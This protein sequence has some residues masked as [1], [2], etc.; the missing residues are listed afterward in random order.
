M[1]FY[2]KWWFW[3]VVILAILIIFFFPKSCG[4]SGG[5]GGPITSIDC[6]CIGVKGPPIF[7]LLGGR[8][9][10]A[11]LTSCYGICLKN[12]CETTIIY[13]NGTRVKK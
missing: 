8:I 10:D 7:I 4:G 5:T 1:V 9:M 2:K 11:S 12:S 3:S 6:S 13:S